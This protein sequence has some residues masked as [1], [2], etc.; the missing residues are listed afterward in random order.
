[1]RAI[2]RAGGGALIPFIVL[3]VIWGSTW[4]AIKGQLAA[5]P[6]SWSITWRFVLAGAAMVVLAKVRRESLRLPPGA[7]ALAVLT[8]LTQFWLNYQLLYESER[9]LTSGLAAVLYALLFVP[10]ALLSALF[11]GS[12]VSARFLAGSA[13]AIAG[14]A[15]L[16]LHEVRLGPAGG[17]AMWGIVLAL[18]GILAASISNVAQAAPAA[19]ASGAVPF[20]AWSMIWGTLIDA[21]YAYAVDG[22]PVI[23]TSPAYLAALGWLAIVGSVL[24]FP[25]NFKLIRDMGAAKAAYIGVTTPIVAMLLSTLF[26]DYRWTLLAAAGAVLAMIGLVIALSSRRDD[27]PASSTARSPSR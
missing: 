16:L 3:S 23:D 27:Q 13:V 6:P 18:G 22:P 14:I 9:Y 1:V 21:A 11:L 24:A 15:L 19:R 17:M 4:L 2:A 25:M 8:G 20:M 10:N 26:E 12:G 7:Q 5:V